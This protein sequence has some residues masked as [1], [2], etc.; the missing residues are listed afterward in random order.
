MSISNLSRPR[1]SFICQR[2]NPKALLRLFCFPYAGGS[3]QVFQT[4]PGKLPLTVEVC[5]LQLPGR[6]GRMGEAPYLSAEQV[7]EEVIQAFPSYEDKPFAFFGHSMGALVSFEVARRLRRE[8]RAGPLQMFISGNRAPHLPRRGEPTYNLPEPEFI[9]KIK[10]LNGT[11]QEVLE[12]PEL[13]QLILP[14]LRAD[15]TVCQTYSYRP[16]PP[17][18]C[19]ISVFGGLQ[20]YE[21][22]REGVEAWREQT[23][24]PFSLRMLAGDHFFIHS[25]QAL[26]LNM[27]SRELQQ[28]LIKVA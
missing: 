21:V 5:T 22:G 8:R 14:I 15:F 20:D 3:A 12:H 6:G 7:I 26:L 18:L 11:P 19:P 2:P 13:M 16:E 1:R 24:G 10:S 4:W 27:I 17:L 23:S 25:S 9:E 28:L